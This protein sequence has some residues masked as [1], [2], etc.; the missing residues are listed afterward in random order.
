MFLGYQ[1]RSFTMR[2][3]LP[4]FFGFLAGAFLLYTPLSPDLSPG[5]A[6]GEGNK[7]KPRPKRKK[8]QEEGEL[9][10]A[11]RAALSDDGKLLL[12]AYRS[13]L[14]G[15]TDALQLWGATTGKRLRAYAEDK[16]DVLHFLP[17]GKRAL[18]AGHGKLF[19]LTIPSGKPVHAIDA[20][21]GKV[22]LLATSPT[23][24]YALTLGR[25]KSKRR[26]KL[27]N[28]SNGK[29]V[30][31]IVLPEEPINF[32]ALSPDCQRAL[33][34]AYPGY[35]TGK[36]RLWDLKT[37]KTIRSWT[38][39]QGWAGPVAFSPGGQLA[40]SVRRTR[41]EKEGSFRLVLWKVATGETVRV[42]KGE[43]QVS[44]GIGGAG[45]AF[46]PGGKQVMARGHGPTVLFYD[47][48]S[49]KELHAAPVRPPKVKVQGG[50]GMVRSNTKA[51]ALSADGRRA[52]VLG[53]NNHDGAI[54]LTVRIWDLERGKLLRE[55]RDPTWV[56]TT[57]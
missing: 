35:R 23:G 57:K 18:V 52:A 43:D 15:F 47:I 19:L 4:W 45:A 24:D 36:V 48:K 7:G 3:G 40:L 54:E 6:A 8:A 1:P 53:G 30:R 56:A 34:A 14:E 44:T 39:A 20:Y 12:V 38:K 28:L 16:L 29:L 27:W 2:K 9:V 55:W 41:G 51:F 10:L 22:L 13:N 21:Q 25:E 5:R 46:L 31:S 26:L 49:G 33:T 42:L 11:R 50:V 37:G 17:G 32:L